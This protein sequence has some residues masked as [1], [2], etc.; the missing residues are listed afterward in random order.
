V[1]EC[2]YKQ[3]S[4]DDE[5]VLCK[6]DG[7]DEE[8][9]YNDKNHARNGMEDPVIFYKSSKHIMKSYFGVHL[10]ELKFEVVK[11]GK[12]F[13]VD[14]MGIKNITLYTKFFLLYMYHKLNFEVQMLKTCYFMNNIF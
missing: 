7:D 11:Y 12:E 6:L 10:D 1:I 13:R 14:F 4:F 5:H 3:E 9:L 2:Q 8:D